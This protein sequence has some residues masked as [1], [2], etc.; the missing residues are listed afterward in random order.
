[1]FKNLDHYFGGRLW[2]RIVSLGDIRTVAPDTI[3]NTQE[4][5]PGHLYC[6]ISGSAKNCY[7][8]SD[9][10]ERIYNFLIAPNI[11][12]ETS[13]IDGRPYLC[14][15]VSITECRVSV[16]SY[17][18]LRQEFEDSIDFRDFMLQMM[19]LKMRCAHL[20]ARYSGG[21]L[22]QRTANL[23]LNFDTFS[24]SPAPI[25]NISIAQS[26][27]AKMLCASRPMVNRL[28]KDFCDKGLIS[29][30]RGRIEIKD[31]DGLAEIAVL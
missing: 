11:S 16:I 8:L 7:Y 2:E 13:M 18:V 29:H 27:L 20:H 5:I 26:E 9:G 31:P 25:E 23:L 28:L 4:E 21:S 15:M 10:A 30:K 3:I 12:A 6:L 24:M 1:M 22:A 19:A 17:D 14:N